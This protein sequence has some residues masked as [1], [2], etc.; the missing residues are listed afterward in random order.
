MRGPKVVPEAKRQSHL[1][2]TIFLDLTNASI[3]RLK[4]QVTDTGYQV[5]DILQ[6]LS[7]VNAWEKKHKKTGE[8]QWVS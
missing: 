4:N 7:T 3:Q 8:N 6:I 1:F 5:T 2:Q